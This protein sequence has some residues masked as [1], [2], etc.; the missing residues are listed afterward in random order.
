MPG[1]RWGR[2]RRGSHRRRRRRSGRRGCG[3]GAGAAGCAAA[4]G[5]GAAGG[6][7]AAWVVGAGSAAGAAGAGPLLH[8]PSKSNPLNANE[9]IP[10][11][12]ASRAAWPFVEW[13]ALDNVCLFIILSI[14]AKVSAPSCQARLFQLFLNQRLSRSYC[15]LMLSSLGLHSIF[16][17]PGSISNRFRTDDAAIRS[18]KPCKPQRIVTRESRIDGGGRVENAL[19]LHQLRTLLLDAVS[20]AQDCGC[21]V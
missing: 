8:P 16:A 4:A 10:A 21:R 7:A 11:Y 19:S 1:W 15:Q 13:I 17:R 5:A 3:A 20:G 12:V 18:S 2:G 9:S 6:G 14:D